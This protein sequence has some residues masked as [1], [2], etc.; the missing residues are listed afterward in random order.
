MLVIGEDAF[1]NQ[2][3]WLLVLLWNSL[4]FFHQRNFDY[5]GWEGITVK[6]W[7]V[8]QRMM[9][10]WSV[11]G[12]L[13]TLACMHTQVHRCTWN[14]EGIQWVTCDLV[15]QLPC[16]F[17]FFLT[18]K[19]NQGSLVSMLTLSNTVCETPGL[20]FTLNTE[21][22]EWAFERDIATKVARL[23]PWFHS[24]ITALATVLV[25]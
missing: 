5:V 4:T 16:S 18:K 2:Y 9:Q 19:D 12:Y 25:S 10:F 11:A 8:S 21:I 17:E 14:T 20:N 24:C 13:S 22:K 3:A 7:T 1:F 6:Q 15:I 23:V